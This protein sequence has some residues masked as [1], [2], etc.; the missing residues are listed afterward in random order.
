MS[1]II[2]WPET[3][4]TFSHYETILL[5]NLRIVTGVTTYRIQP[6]PATTIKLAGG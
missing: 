4:E 5:F 2:Q 6:L 1:Y 3:S